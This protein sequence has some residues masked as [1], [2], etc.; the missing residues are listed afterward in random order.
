MY[1]YLNK[2]VQQVRWLAQVLSTKKQK[3]YGINT[4]PLHKPFIYS[5]SFW[6]FSHA[7]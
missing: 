1:L 7:T 2:K 5:V 4:A 6:F 3:D